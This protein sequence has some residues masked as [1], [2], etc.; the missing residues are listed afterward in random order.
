MTLITV[1]KGDYENKH[2]PDRNRT[3]TAIWQAVRSGKIKRGKCR[4]CGVTKTQAHHY[5]S[6]SGTKGIV[7]LCDKHHRAA[8]VRLRKAKQN[9]SKG[10]IL[11]S[12]GSKH[13]VYMIAAKPNE[14]DTDSQWWLPE[15]IEVLAWRFLIN[16][17]LQKADI[18]EEHIQKRPDIFLVESYI[19]P[20][21]FMLIDYKGQKRTVTQG[22]WIV[23]FW[24]PSDETWN[25]ILQGQLTGASPRGPGQVITGEVPVTN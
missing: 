12:D 3:Y 25:R 23:G 9:I 11:K 14:L 13:I 10:E 20:V 7:W 24:V 15:D 4:I 8:H 17:R 21:T 6:Y 2:M 1:T 5:G 18:F 19:A 22:T 16:Y